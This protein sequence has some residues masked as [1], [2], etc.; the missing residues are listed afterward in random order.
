M[1]RARRVWGYV[2]LSLGLL[3]LVGGI[4]GYLEGHLSAL[5][6]VFCGF[7]LFRL[8]RSLTRG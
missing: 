3:W 1:N 7:V 4:F 6:F 8:G 2:V 5:L